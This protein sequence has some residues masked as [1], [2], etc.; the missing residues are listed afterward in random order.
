MMNLTSLECISHCFTLIPCL[1]NCGTHLVSVLRLVANLKNIIVTALMR[2]LR[3]L[4]AGSLSLC[5]SKD[6]E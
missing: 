6:V 3:P 1:Y 4:S 2:L 5:P